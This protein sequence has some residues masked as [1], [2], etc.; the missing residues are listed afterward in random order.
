MKTTNQAAS[1]RR[2]KLQDVPAIKHCIDQAY[3]PV[4]KRLADLPDVSAGV[5]E[6]IEKNVVLVAETG[7]KIAGC[8]ILE[9]NGGVAHLMN[10][11]VDPEFKGFG[12]GKM[13]LA[14]VEDTA[15]RN[16]VRELHLATHVGM[17]ENVSL[18]TH[19]GWSETS[20]N[21]NK[22]LMKKEI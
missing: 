5:E 20:R 8:A 16:G 7:S 10:I 17:P 6:D 14:A 19:L 9:M 15:I 3:A 11:A 13:L 4:K 1:I 22:V 21:S 18:Y 2:A 12:L